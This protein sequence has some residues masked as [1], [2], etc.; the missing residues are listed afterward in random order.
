MVLI[1]LLLIIK[2]SSSCSIDADCPFN[3]YCNGGV[4]SCINGY[5]LDCT[6]S[7]GYVG[8]N[9]VLGPFVVN[10]PSY[11]IL[12][13]EIDKDISYDIYLILSS[14]IIFPNYFNAQLMAD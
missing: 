8:D 14:N 4:C 3:S 6:I 2:A 13:S 9:T 11:F 10:T 1:M 5:I 7:A 12:Q